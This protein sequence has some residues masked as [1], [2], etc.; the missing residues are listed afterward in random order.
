VGA[1]TVAKSTDRLEFSTFLTF[2]FKFDFILLYRQRCW[3]ANNACDWQRRWS[4]N[5]GRAAA[6][7]LFL[8]FFLLDVLTYYLWSLWLI[9]EELLGSRRDLFRA[10]LGSLRRRRAATELD[11]VSPRL[12]RCCCRRQEGRGSERD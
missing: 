2:K 8:V 5:D 7:E 1:V 3:S 9:A 12:L 4:A 10:F 6:E 11:D